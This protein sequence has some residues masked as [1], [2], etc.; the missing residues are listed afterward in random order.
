MCFSRE[1]DQ[2]QATVEAAFLIPVLLLCLMLLIQ[3][4]ILLYDRMVMHAAAAE[5]CRM[6]ETKPAGDSSEPYEGFVLRG[7]ASVPQQE[8]FHVHES[9]CSWEVELSGDETSSEVSVRITGEVRPLPLF[10]WGAKALGIVN[11]K[12]NFE[13]ETEVSLELR[14]EWQGDSEQGLDPEGWIDQWKE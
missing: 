12:G 6:L 5:G 4:G 7:L 9:G 8:N 1:R 14:P 10:D 13:V 2:G 3:P 11:G